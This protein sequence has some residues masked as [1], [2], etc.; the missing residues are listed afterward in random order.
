MLRIHTRYLE[1]IVEA[2]ELCP[3]AKGARQSGA[4][5]RRVIADAPLDGALAAIDHFAGD[6]KI[7]VAILIFPRHEAGAED[8]DRFV[9]NVRKAD[10]ARRTTRAPFALAAFHPRAAW[11]DES[12][13]RLV[14]FFRRSP[15]PSIQLVR[16]AALDAVRSSAPSGKFLFDG[17]AAAM[18][19][20]ER[21][22]LTIPV[23]ERIAR[24]NFDRF[25]A[26]RAELERALGD[27]EADRARSY[28]RF[29]Q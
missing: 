21:R 4:L 1:E 6:E 20:L 27:I 17:S 19:E 5:A 11:G 28:A 26:A 24:D 15:D 14:M 23:S 25:H 7:V 13:E 10:L 18:A 16:F 2:H 29:R 9:A 22:A 8:F 3:W 12:P